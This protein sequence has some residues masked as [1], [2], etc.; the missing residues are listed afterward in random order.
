MKTQNS[1]SH[2]TL[3][4]RRI[5]LAGITNG[6]TKTA[7]AQTIGKDKSTVGKEIKLHRS[8]TYKCKMPLECNHYKKCVYDVS[9]LLTAQST[10]LSI[11]QDATALLVP[12]TVVPTGLAAALINTNTV[13]KMLIWITVPL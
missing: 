3:E 11:V 5:I 12:V 6:S 2:L 13:R 7:I 8:L 1:F 9:V 10:V 4:E